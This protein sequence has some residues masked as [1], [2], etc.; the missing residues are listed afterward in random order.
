MK[1]K[2]SFSPLNNKSGQKAY[3]QQCKRYQPSPDWF[4][5]EQP[6]SRFKNR[7][8]LRVCIIWLFFHA[9]VREPYQLT[10]RYVVLMKVLHN[11]SNRFQQ[12]LSVNRKAQK[13][14][15][16]NAWKWLPKLFFRSL[17]FFLLKL[18]GRGQGSIQHQN[19]S[20]SCS[21]LILLSYLHNPP[22][23]ATQLC[24]S[25]PT[26]FSLGINPKDHDEKKISLLIS[27]ATDKEWKVKRI[28]TLPPR[29]NQFYLHFVPCLFLH[30]Q[31]HSARGKGNEAELGYSDQRSW[32]PGHHAYSCIP[33]KPTNK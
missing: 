27:R 1:G 3:I 30:T 26:A 29:L 5:T 2:T 22:N 24:K 16:N 13:S 33:V 28:I 17:P 23:P 32:R 25:Q 9:S 18:K 19:E 14:R 12:H 7:L 11:W 15:K 20:K 31:K 6:V 21:R 4:I 10:L 8:G